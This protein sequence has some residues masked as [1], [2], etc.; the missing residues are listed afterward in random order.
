MVCG[1]FNCGIDNEVPSGINSKASATLRQQVHVSLL[2]AY[3]EQLTATNT[4]VCSRLRLTDAAKEML[5]ILRELGIV[6][7]CS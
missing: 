6:N 4:I 1:E 2:Q 3:G 7:A 5:R